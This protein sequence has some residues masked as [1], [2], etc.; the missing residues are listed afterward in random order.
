[1]I[2]D[3]IMFKPNSIDFLS[4]LTGFKYKILDNNLKL[5]S[6]FL[7]MQEDLDK[8]KDPYCIGII[9][10]D[11]LFRKKDLRKISEIGKMLIVDVNAVRGRLDYIR[12]IRTFVLE[13]IKYKVNIK[14]A[15]FATNEDELLSTKQ[16][17][18]L[19]EYLGF[20]KGKD[21]LINKV[22]I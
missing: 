16:V 6:S 19:A 13:S 20:K 18:V 12:S 5:G 17:E 15:T 7:I 3:I 9:Y 21:A 1:M 14:F 8:I 22:L 10:R 2:Y 11:F 4:S